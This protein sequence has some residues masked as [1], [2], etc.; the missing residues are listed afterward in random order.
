[1]DQ[2]IASFISR[3]F[4]KPLRVKL[5]RNFLNPSQTVRPSDTILFEQNG[6]D[7]GQISFLRSLRVSE[8][9]MR[10]DPP[11]NL[12]ILPAYDVNA[13]SS[14]LPISIVAQGGIIVPMAGERSWETVQHTI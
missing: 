1:M 3:A 4:P 5:Q 9:K 10:N 2:T 14:V 12:S 11:P 13:L 8:Q 6:Q 7:G